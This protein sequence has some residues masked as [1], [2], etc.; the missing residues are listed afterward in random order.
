VGKKNE[1]K[2]SGDEYH[3]HEFLSTEPG[4]KRLRTEACNCPIGTTHSTYE[5]P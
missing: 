2:K 3:V 4:H 1:P 5:S